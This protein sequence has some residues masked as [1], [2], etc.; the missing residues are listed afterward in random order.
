MLL[1]CGRSGENLISKHDNMMVMITKQ[2]QNKQTLFLLFQLEKMVER[3]PTFKSSLVSVNRGSQIH[4]MI[5][6]SLFLACAT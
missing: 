3:D 6:K 5:L 1:E 4:L 2:L